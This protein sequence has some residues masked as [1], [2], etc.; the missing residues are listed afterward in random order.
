MFELMLALALS[1]SLVISLVDIYSQSQRRYLT[2]MTVSH[3][4][5]E[6]VFAVKRMEYAL[7]DAIA[8]QFIQRNQLTSIWRRR[9]RPQGGVLECQ[10]L[11]GNPVRFYVTQVSWQHQSGRHIT[12]LFEKKGLSPRLELVPFV[13]SLTAKPLSSTLF[14]FCVQVMAL[15][16]VLRHKN[17]VSKVS[18]GQEYADRTWYGVVAFK[19]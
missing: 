2:L 19:K 13:F 12:A 17:K 11:K 8:C 10:L 9:L 15:N 5:F 6:G 4:T 16:P 3:M 7:R 18:F 14:Q 1:A